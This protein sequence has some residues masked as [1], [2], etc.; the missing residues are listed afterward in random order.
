[1]FYAAKNEDNEIYES[2]SDTERVLAI[3]DIHIISVSCQWQMTY[4]S[5]NGALQ[6]SVFLCHMK[7]ACRTKHCL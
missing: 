1:M 7:T 2:L 5:V 4:I 6:K 3:T